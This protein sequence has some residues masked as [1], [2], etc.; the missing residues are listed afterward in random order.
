MGARFR[1]ASMAAVL[2]LAVLFVTKWPFA[3]ERILERLGD[4]LAS[5]VSCGRFRLTFLPHPGCVLDD[6]VVARGAV[7]LASARRMTLDGSWL[8]VLTLRRRLQLMEV[9]GLVVRLPWPV[10]AP[11]KRNAGGAPSATVNEARFNGAVL[12][13]A[14][15]RFEFRELQIGN[16]GWKSRLS[17]RSSLRNPEPPADLRLNG[18]IG[19]WDGAE[20]PVDGSYELTGADLGKYKGIAGILASKGT[21]KGVLRKIDISGTAGA[22]GFEVTASG[23]RQALQTTFEASVNA[24]NGDV[25]LGRVEAR[26]G[27]T[28]LH[29]SGTVADKTATLDFV[30][31]EARVEDLLY[32]FSK[33]DP[34]AMRGPIELRAHVVLPP[35]DRKF[36]A[37]VRIDGDFSIRRGR[38]SKPLTQAKL[39][40][41]S[42]RARDES[43]QAEQDASGAPEEALTNLRAHV[44]MRDGAARLSAVRFQVPGA[45]AAGGGSY[46]LLSKR[47]D[48][49]GE[50]KMDATVSEAAGGIKSVILK[51]FNFL[52]RRKNSSAGAI[53][54]VAV[55]GIYPR[56]RFQVGLKPAD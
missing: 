14:N 24:R 26:F 23:H 36:L 39:N 29:S 46:N 33:R 1:L 30:S 52:F 47:I 2:A 7:R 53:L 45:A 20:T 44:A 17:V 55:T 34:P 32:M 37:R 38:F 42:A 19:P 31:E 10:P 40:D 11:V 35:E 49:R 25:A 43:K 51:P 22:E 27:K 13:V 21:W 18:S 8:S 41:L 48:L 50:V 28:V 54:P 56:P 12:E 5:D 9:E 16:L 3:Q 6:V 4:S 15:R